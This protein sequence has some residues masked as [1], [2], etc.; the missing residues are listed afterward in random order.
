MKHWKNWLRVIGLILLIGIMASV[1]WTQVLQVIRTLDPAY[2]AGYFACFITMLLLRTARLRL[3]LARLDHRFTFRNCYLATLEPTFMGMV[4]PGRLGEFAR[5]GYIHSH[6]ATLPVAIGVVAAER[7]VDV[8]LLLAFGAAG[9][10]YI[11]A[12]ANNHALAA[13]VALG[14]LLA[15][16][17]SLYG[18]RHWLRFFQK[19][20]GWLVRW[21]PSAIARYRRDLSASFNLV[22]ER[23]VRPVF[24]FGLGCILANFCQIF[25]LAKAFGFQADPL[26]MVFAYAAATLVSL[27][28]ISFGGLGTREATY[29][30]IM[31][32][33]GI[34]R[35]QAMLFS[36]TDGLVFS[37]LFLLLLLAPF[38][39][40]SR[41][42][43]GAPKADERHE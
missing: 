39:I 34:S 33:V 37:L 4:T 7:L 19:H 9:L 17:G 18:Y 35:E 26:V 20:L 21:E 22:I 29:I 10:V 15:I 25:L 3:A 23:A 28:P 1:D 40:S 24:F 5:V 43:N 27:V 13:I 11:F 8:S 2:L 30:M 36:L 16:L 32:Q 6:G 12:P 38:W 31:G 41:L 42:R 14:G